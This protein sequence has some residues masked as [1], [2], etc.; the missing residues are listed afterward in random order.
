MHLTLRLRRPITA[1]LLLLG[2][3]AL[4]SCSRPEQQIGLGIQPEED[5]LGANQTDT[6]TITASTVVI[7][8]LRTDD[9]LFSLLGN[10]IDPNLGMATV[11]LYT[12]VRLS[13]N[14]VDFGDASLIFIDS[15]VLGMEHQ[16]FHHGNI[17]PMNFLVQEIDDE[18]V[19]DS[20]YYNIH[21]RDVLPTDLM[22]PARRTV[23]PNYTDWQF[24]GE[25]SLPPQ[26]RLHLD[27]NFA[28]EKFLS[29]SGLAPLENNDEFLEYFK[30]FKITPLT[31][32]GGVFS[33]NLLDANSNLTMYYR[34]LVD[35]VEDTTSFTFN[36]NDLCSRHYQTHFTRSNSLNGIHATDTLE[37]NP[38]VYA[39]GGANVAA[40]VSFPHIQDLLNIPG[41]VINKAELIIP[42]KAGTERNDIPSQIFLRR[43]L[44]EANALLPEDLIPNF[45]AGGTYDPVNHEYRV[46][47]GRFLEHLLTGD[48]ESPELLIMVEDRFA[49]AN[50]F[51]DPSLNRLVLHGPSVD[52]DVSSSNMRLI[53]THTIAGN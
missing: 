43:P 39:Q 23:T 19:I 15:L 51:V 10:Y 5:L 47:V 44:N 1:A 41:M 45:D 34:E 37:A 49:L 22:D 38:Y 11:E 3:L 25:D 8:S 7:D 28:R 48:I 46:H 33:F 6:V 53:L 21:G 2:I 20:T 14:N 32:D 52:P 26:M 17:R 30:G 18:Y 13:S 40:R 36:I 50:T 9:L 4:H 12:Q 27:T 24:V 35:D 29:Q 16:G 42:V 31:P